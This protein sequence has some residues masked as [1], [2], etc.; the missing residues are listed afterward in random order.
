[1]YKVVITVYC[2]TKMAEKV[3]KLM[4]GCDLGIVDIETEPIEFEYT[5]NTKVNK[6]YL[7]KKKNHLIKGFR[8]NFKDLIIKDIKIEAFKYLTD[9]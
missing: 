4:V 9:K 1:M 6:T 2:T 7:K 5:T 3:T 8:E